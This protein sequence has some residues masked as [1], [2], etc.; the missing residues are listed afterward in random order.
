MNS[1]FP[2][3]VRSAPMLVVRQIKEWA[4]IIIDFETRN[5]Y[6]IRSENGE[7]LAFVIEKD[8]GLLSTLARVFLRSHRPL[9]VDVLDKSSKPMYHLS[10]KFFF[11]FSDLNIH[12]SAHQKTGSIHRRFGIVYK[13]YDLHDELNQ[14][15]ARVK[16]P[17]WR[18]WT[19]PVI[20]TS[21]QVTAKI[22]K[23]WQGLLKEALSDADSFV[24]E[25]GD[26]PWSLNQRLV[27]LFTAVSIDFD[28]FEDNDANN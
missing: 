4:E 26:I 13:K 18:L 23:K 12:D 20:N 6:E 11:F 22:T 28:F 9:E 14:V 2:D 3:I 5:Q 10:R 17:I 15:F 24:V 19:F 27:L 25:Y 8:K 21:G 1:Q 16:A 7:R